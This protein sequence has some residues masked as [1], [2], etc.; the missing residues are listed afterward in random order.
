MEA[1]LRVK[2]DEG[3]FIQ[4][5][6]SGMMMVEEITA[7]NVLISGDKPV[8]EGFDNVRSDEEGY[9]FIASLNLAAF[10][11]LMNRVQKY[12]KGR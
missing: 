5:Q 1:T 4:L 12:Q 11:G 8:P 9:G 2:V 6:D 7:E 10:E 3:D